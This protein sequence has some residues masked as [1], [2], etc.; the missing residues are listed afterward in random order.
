MSINKTTV[1]PD[2]LCAFE[3]SKL[4]KHRAEH[5]RYLF[6]SPYTLMYNKNIRDKMA[7]FHAAARPLF[8][9]KAK[10][11]ALGGRLTMNTHTGEIKS[12][13]LDDYKTADE[14]LDCQI[15][16]LKKL[17]FGEQHDYRS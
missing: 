1:I 12:E 13:L 3:L 17:I 10:L 6:L 15:E 9:L 4:E 5:Y 11:W 14:Q 8:D 16:A 7:E 2:A